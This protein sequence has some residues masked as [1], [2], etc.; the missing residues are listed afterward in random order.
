MVYEDIQK[1][2]DTGATIEITYI[3]NSGIES[4]RK[5]SDITYSSVWG[6]GFSHITAFCHTRQEQ[7][8]FRIDSISKVTF[9]DGSDNNAHSVFLLHYHLVLVVKYRRKVFCDINYSLWDGIK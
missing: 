4:V 2:I 7:R 6:T 5:L 8:T 3:N 9:L 1:A